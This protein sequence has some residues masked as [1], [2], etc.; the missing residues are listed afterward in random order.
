MNCY[1]K[2]YLEG[3]GPDGV[4]IAEGGPTGYT[5]QVTNGYTSNGYSVGQDKVQVGQDGITT[6]TKKAREFAYVVDPMSGKEITVEERKAR[7]RA[8]AKYQSSGYLHCERYFG[9]RE[10]S[11]ILP[12]GPENGAC[13][14]TRNEMPKT[15]NISGYAGHVHGKVDTFAK[16]HRGAIQEAGQSWTAERKGAARV[17]SFGTRAT[18]GQTSWVKPFKDKDVSVYN[19]E[20]SQEYHIP[21]YTG[22]IRGRQNLAG[23][24]YAGVT[25]EALTED[26]DYLLK[27]C[28]VP[29]KPNTKG[30]RV[31]IGAASCFSIGSVGIPMGQ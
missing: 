4:R 2:T 23:R 28:D 26:F 12:N 13:I 24:T 30:R 9:A 14:P 27:N 10:S 21:G 19:Q 22:H 31:S 16:D 7:M 29:C 17:A 15:T 5:Q 6:Y 8:A 3:R 25:R 20:N 18:V 11:I 1:N